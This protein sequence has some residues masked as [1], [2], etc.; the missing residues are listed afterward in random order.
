MPTF[1]RIA[2]SF[3]SLRPVISSPSI[4]TSPEVGFIRP[5]MC[6]SRTL[7]PPPLLP[8]MT[9]VS[10]FSTSRSTPRRI[11]WEPIV[12]T[13]LRKVIISLASVGKDDVEDQRQKEICDQDGQTTD[14][15]GFGRRATDSFGA[16][17]GSEPLMA[18]HKDDDDGEDKSLYQRHFHV[19][20]PREFPHVIHV[21]DAIDAEHV[22]P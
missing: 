10:P 3:R 5:M 20:D 15:H 11:S 6:L 19:A 8:T 7:L 12:F 17:F 4:S 2:T 1:F 9:T 14:H 16:F 13:I 22:H 21:I 18:T